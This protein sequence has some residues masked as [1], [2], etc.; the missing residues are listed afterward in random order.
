[1]TI[2]SYERVWVALE[3]KL[4]S[5][6]AVEAEVG[7]DVQVYSNH[8][9]VLRPVLLANLAKCDENHVARFMKMQEEGREQAHAEA[10]AQV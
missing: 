1:M 3:L 6:P 2:D 10:Q 7:R 5:A 9:C 8:C 4:Y